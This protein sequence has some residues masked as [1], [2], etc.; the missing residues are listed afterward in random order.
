MIERPSPNHDARPQGGAIDMLV[1]HYTGMKTAEEALSRLCDPQAK[2][3]AHYTID[4]D[5]EIYAHVP[6]A[7]RAWHAG[8]SYWAGMRNVNACSI[9]IELV[10]P[11]HEFGYE[12]FAEPQ[13]A[14]LIDLASGILKRHP[15][16]PHR[17]LGHSD[18]APARKQDP[19]EL[20]SWA[21]L[22]DFD[23]GLWPHDHGAALG[24]S[25]ES[26][27][28]AFGYGL[29]DAPLEKVIAAFQRHFRPARVDGVADAETK[30]RLAA[31]LAQLETVS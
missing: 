7:R 5:G 3:S 2:V 9:G 11:G 17:V 19:G 29:S 30:R 16:P 8:V 20:F 25:V 26:A 6:E 23:I 24:Q 22:A 12:P 27:L 28:F 21:Q 14:A 4:R 10:N 13:M 31:L 1:L 18:V 15:I